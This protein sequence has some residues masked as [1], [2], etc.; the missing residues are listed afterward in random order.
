LL[1]NKKGAR[2]VFLF[3]KEKIPLPLFCFQLGHSLM[4]VIPFVFQPGKEIPSSEPFLSFCKLMH[5]VHNSMPLLRT[6]RQNPPISRALS[7]GKWQQSS[8]AK[9]A[10]LL[11]VTPEVLRAYWQKDLVRNAARSEHILQ[12]IRVIGLGHA[13]FGEATSFN[14]WLLKPAYGLAGRLPIDLFYVNGGIDLVADE[15]TRIAYG[16]VV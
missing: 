2:E 7:I 3:S 13:V 12:L 10:S 15:L 5:T 14:S 8:A 9:L 11:S 16:D 6:I 1:K 4:S